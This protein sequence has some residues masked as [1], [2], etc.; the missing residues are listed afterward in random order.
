M[1]EAKA[2]VVGLLALQKLLDEGKIDRA[3]ERT[4]YPTYL[5]SMFR[6]IRFGLNEAH[7]KGMALQLSWFL[8]AGAVRAGPDGRFSVDAARIRE[9]V[10]SLAREILSIQARGDRAAAEALLERMA[11]VRPEVRRV[12]D[13]L[14][15]VPV[16][17]APRYPTADE[18]A[19]R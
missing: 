11:V 10:R 13:R 5:A 17:V 8:D 2:D 7:G 15:A 3:L 18:L 19:P 6:S 4:L 14:S 9:A 1:E 16:D 12:L